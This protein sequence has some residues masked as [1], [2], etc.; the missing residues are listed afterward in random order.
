MAGSLASDDLVTQVLHGEQTDFVPVA[1]SYEGLGPLQFHRLELNW[2]KWWH[3]LENA[4]TDLL[5]VDYDTYLAVELEVH[6]DIIE[7]C[8][9]R[10]AW[11]SVPHNDTPDEIRG[12]AIARRGEDLFW[13][14]P[15]G[16]ASWIPPSRAAQHEAEIVER[17]LSYA[18]LW[19]RAEGRAIRPRRL[20]PRAS[21]RP[22]PQPG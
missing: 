11:L 7:R 8:Y 20:P 17:S 22:D 18:D 19:D 3:H 12:F 15:S 9:P 1:P 13:L 5:P 2:R 21:A 4:H 14:S 16:H 6:V 10:P